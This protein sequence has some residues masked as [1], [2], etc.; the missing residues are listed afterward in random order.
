[1]C[2]D[3]YAEKM[4]MMGSICGSLGEND[5]DSLVFTLDSKST[6]ESQNFAAMDYIKTDIDEVM[7]E[8]NEEDEFGYVSDRAVGEF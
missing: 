2:T 1:M 4:S 6:K 7:Y 3:E 5:M 8:I